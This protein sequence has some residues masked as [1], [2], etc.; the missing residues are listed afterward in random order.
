ML[1]PPPPPPEAAVESGM[2]TG[3][4]QSLHQLPALLRCELY[5][6]GFQNLIYL[7]NIHFVSFEINRNESKMIRNCVI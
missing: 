3:N 6:Y 7:I 2:L 4:G 1:K 5:P